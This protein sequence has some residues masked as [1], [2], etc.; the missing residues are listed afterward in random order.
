[1]S[2]EDFYYVSQIIASTAV[3]A[4]L[5]YLALQTRQTSRNQQAQMHALRLQTINALIMK[6]GDPSFS[7]TCQ[8]GLAAEPGMSATQAREFYFFVFSMLYGMQEQFLEH[9]EGMIDASRWQ[10]TRDVFRYYLSMPGFRA[11]FRVRRLGMDPGFVALGDTL[12][13]ETN[14]QSV[15]PDLS[16]GWL[17][18]AAEERAAMVAQK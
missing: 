12:I 16:I 17:T 15:P 14:A 1:M 4:S 9:K 7:G 18:V 10:A 6:M 13:A 8:L 2:L 5:V 3:F 11:V